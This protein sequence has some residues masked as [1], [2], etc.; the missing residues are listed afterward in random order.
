MSH[1]VTGSGYLN[2]PVRTL[3]IA[4]DNRPGSYPL[5]ISPA[6]ASKSSQT[7]RPYRDNVMPDTPVVYARAKVTFSGIPGSTETITLTNAASV[8]HTFTFRTNNTAFDAGPNAYNVSLF[9]LDRTK[10][11]YDTGLVTGQILVKRA[12]ERFIAAVNAATG[13][14][15]TASSTDK[16]NVVVLTQNIP[17]T[18][19]NTTNSYVTDGEFVVENFTGGNSGAVRY[20]FGISIGSAG[21]VLDRVLSTDV[22]GTLDV[23]TSGKAG[24]LSAPSDQHPYAVFQ[25][26]DESSAHQAFG[27]HTGGPRRYGT[28]AR[29]SDEFFTRGSVSGSLDEPLWVKDKIVIDLTPTETTVLKYTNTASVATYGMAYYNFSQRRWEGVGTGYSS[30]D[31]FA[32]GA[33][34]SF[35]FDVTHAGFSQSCFMGYPA[36]ES[37]WASCTDTFGFPVHPKYH[38]TSSQT[39]SVSSL[40]DRPFV[41]EKIVYEFSASSGGTAQILPGNHPIATGN[42]MINNC[43]GTFF[44]LNQRIANPDPGQDTSYTSY[45]YADVGGDTYASPGWTGPLSSDRPPKGLIYTSSLPVNRVISRGGSPVY[46]N[47]VRD[48]VTFARVGAVWSDYDTEIVQNLQSPGDDHPAKFMDLAIGVPNSGTY[49]GYF[50]V[51]ADVKSPQFNNAFSIYIVTSSFRVFASKYSFTR[52]SLDLPTGR[53]RRS[54][55]CASLPLKTKLGIGGNSDQVVTFY[56]SDTVSSPYVILPGDNLVFGWQSP[57]SFSHLYDGE[58]F[59]IGPGKGK[60]VLYGSYLQD[61]KPVHDIYKD[62]LNSDAAHEAL[63]AGPWVL[64]RFES[65]PQMMYSSSMREEHVTGTMVTRGA[66]GKLVVTD[67]NDL[68]IGGVRAVSARVSDGTVGARWSF[69]RNNRLFDEQEQYYDSMQPNP[70]DVLFSDS[71]VRA[72]QF[73]AGVSYALLMLPG[74]TFYYDSTLPNATAAFNSY[75]NRSLFIRYPFQSE[76]SN[77]SR[78]KKIG[79]RVLTGKQVP[80]FT[81]DA[82][83]VVSFKTTTINFAITLLTG[84]TGT[85]GPTTLSSFLR[86][87]GLTPGGASFPNWGGFLS[88]LVTPSL[89]ETNPTRVDTVPASPAADDASGVNNFIS[90][91]MGCF[92]NGYLRMNQY[93]IPAFGNSTTQLKVLIYR[94]TKHGLINPTPLFSNA[95]FN[96]TQF[97]QFRDMMEQRQYTRFSLNNN[98]LTDSAVEVQFINRGATPGTLNIVSGSF[99]NSS[100]ISKFATSEHPYDDAL[101]DYDQIWDRDTPLPETLIAL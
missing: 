89:L 25:P 22:S 73:S 23:P 86:P 79:S 34:S 97:G 39:L 41:V 87:G 62:Q 8:S 51:A 16:F 12:A 46:V 58:S 14:M 75:S 9:A 36:T 38:A 96:G 80:A 40:V 1:L 93:A 47:A 11:Q 3:L 42:K 57:V 82:F 81:F 33:D 100:N 99:T 63:P 70:L 71:N 4:D 6:V 88:P 21:E 18:V 94:G 66:D 53:A 45:F 67:V 61:D 44:I 83:D 29:L 68:G 15:I 52:N 74:E 32:L 101:S 60:L 35:A 49:G 26:Y 92:G 28:Q 7:T 37:G 76:Y 24:L 48:L 17:G 59:S 5:H 91:L 72:L 98:T 78:V 90:R 69:F 50:T 19:G 95:V 77:I 10:T 64:D 56:E 65:E 13:S 54:E 30:N 84:S 85:P 2:S 31:A 27:V 55:Y 20:P 43:G